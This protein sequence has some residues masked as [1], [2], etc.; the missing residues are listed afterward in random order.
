M[1]APRKV[2]LLDMPEDSSTIRA[3]RIPNAEAVGAAD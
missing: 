1:L 2:G 3:C